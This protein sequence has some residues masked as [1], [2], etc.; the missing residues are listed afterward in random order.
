MRGAWFARLLATGG[1][2]GHDTFVSKV[3]LQ[4]RSLFS[5]TP[6]IKDPISGDYGLVAVLS[7]AVIGGVAVVAKADEN[8]NNARVRSPS[9]P[10][11]AH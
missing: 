6:S 2:N 7:F 10:V 4:I 11:C 3:P 9:R 8:D 1:K 5:K